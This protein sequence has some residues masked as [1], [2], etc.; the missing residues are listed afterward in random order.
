MISIFKSYEDTH[1]CS[2]DEKIEHFESFVNKMQLFYGTIDFKNFDYYYDDW[3]QDDLIDYPTFPRDGY[4]RVLG[5]Y[6]I[7]LAIVAN[8][9]EKGVKERIEMLDSVAKEDSRINLVTLFLSD[10]EIKPE[11]VA[12]KNRLAK[13]RPNRFVDM[14]SSYDLCLHFMLQLSGLEFFDDNKLTIDGGAIEYCSIPVSYIRYVPFLEGYESKSIEILDALWFAMELLHRRYRDDYFSQMPTLIKANKYKGIAQLLNYDKIHKSL[15]EQIKIFKDPTLYHKYNREEVF[16]SLDKLKLFALNALI[17][18][19]KSAEGRRLQRKYYKER[20]NAAVSC[21][22]P[23][24][25]K[26]KALLEYTSLLKSE[27]SIIR[28]WEECLAEYFKII[29]EGRPKSEGRMEHG[30]WRTEWDFTYR[31]GS[32][33]SSK[34]L[35]A[36]KM[37]QDKIIAYYEKRRN[38]EMVEKLCLFEIDRD[39]K[40]N[41]TIENNSRVQQLYTKLGAIYEAKVTNKKCVL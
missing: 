1:D 17:L 25:I 31:C 38:F 5:N 28:L 4:S 26:V 35:Y 24:H 20:Y 2:L 22:L 9:N 41:N 27:K 40:C 16:I 36:S 19:N 23:L 7:T 37:L 34:E 8:A 33:D 12:L 30:E 15:K 10:E 3:I 18:D 6:D 21:K 32:F 13:E 14:R 39:S 29:E 11:V